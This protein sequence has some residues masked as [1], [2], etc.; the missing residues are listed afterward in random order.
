MPFILR[1]FLFTA[2]WLL[3]ASL[4]A[5]SFPPADSLASRTN[6]VS[7]RVQQRIDS[8]RQTMTIRQDQAQAYHD[9][10]LNY[11]QAR[12][13]EASRI[14]PPSAPTNLPTTPALRQTMSDKL[15]TLPALPSTPSV[16][17]LPSADQLATRFANPKAL[18]QLRSVS[19]PGGR[20]VQQ[21]TQGLP[22]ASAVLEEQLAQQEA[23]P[24]LVRQQ[25]ALETWK[26]NSLA[27]PSSPET[28]AEQMKQRAVE[29]VKHH[30]AQHPDAVQEGQEQ[31]ADLKKKYTQVQTEQERYEKAVSLKKEAWAA[32]LLLGS[33]FQVYR[34]PRLSVDVLPFMGYRFNTRWSVGVGA[35]YRVPATEPL[36]QARAFVESVVYRGFLLHAAY[37]RSWQPQPGDQGQSMITD[38]H[39]LGGVGKTYR[40]TRKLRGTTLLLFRPEPSSQVLNLVRWNLRTGV[41]LSQ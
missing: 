24:P 12:S 27:N 29:G 7:E 34:E 33:Y 13:D 11:L 35:S 8:L 22:N 9:S 26:D 14:L 21:G 28:I 17:P 36:Y 38:H 40:I 25:Q 20:Y 19:K 32:H 23:V 37:E 31:L 2:P 18:D 6:R 5:Q 30:L 15:P 41:F 4:R 10:V 39:L 3:S 16:P 1:L